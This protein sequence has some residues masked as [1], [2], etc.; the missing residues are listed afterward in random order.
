MKE[1]V[2]SLETSKKLKRLGVE[3]K[4]VFCHVKVG[5][6]DS[7]KHTLMKINVYDICESDGYIDSDE[8]AAFTAEELRGLIIEVSQ[9]H[10]R[11]LVCRKTVFASLWCWDYMDVYVKA[12]TIA[13][14]LGLLLVKVLEAGEE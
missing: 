6:K 5:E 9:E 14:A 3:Q 13:E 4:A 8:T 1:L 11:L 7:E 10:V 2:T 12:D